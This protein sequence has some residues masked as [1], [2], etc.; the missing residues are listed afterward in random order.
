M[1]EKKGYKI[2]ILNTIDFSKSM[3]YNPFAY[4]RSEKDILKFVTTL[5][6]NTQ[7]EGKQSGEDFWVKAE[8][9]L[10]QALIGYIFYEGRKENKNMNM[11]VEMINDMEVREDDE[12][13]ENSVDKAFKEPETKNPNHFAARQYI[14]IGKPLI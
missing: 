14:G 8:K 13:F 7:G 4:I 5:I 9:L 2:K 6:A 1:L 11:L 12:T 10:Y 3:K